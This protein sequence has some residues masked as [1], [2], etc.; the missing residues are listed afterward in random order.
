MTLKQFIPQ[1]YCLK[2][3]GCCRFKQEYSVWLP[4]LLDEE[5]QYFLDNKEIPAVSLT[6]DK[7]IHPVPGPQ[8][9]GFICA[10]LDPAANKCRIYSHRPFECQLYPFLLNLRGKKVILTVDLNCPYIRE[11]LNSKEFKAYVDELA[12]FLNSAQ[13]IKI[14]KANPQLL[15]AYEEVAELVELKLD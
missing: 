7:K 8:Q 13:Q 14:L 3:K 5:I 1:A 4:C 11:N 2:C 15:Q 12:A 10:F 6:A 9:E